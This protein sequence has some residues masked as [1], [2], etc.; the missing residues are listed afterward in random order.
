MQ[1]GG[2]VLLVVPLTLLALS[3]FLPWGLS[4]LGVRLVLSKES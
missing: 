4:P 1:V 3:G 2:M